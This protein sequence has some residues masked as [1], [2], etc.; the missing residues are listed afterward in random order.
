MTN[1]I[2]TLDVLRQYNELKN[3][4][5][6]TILHG[7]RL[8]NDDVSDEMH[9]IDIRVQYTEGWLD[10]AQEN[11]DKEITT[12]V[13]D[14]AREEEKPEYTPDEIG[15]QP[16][17][18]STSPLPYNLLSGTP[19][20]PTLSEDTIDFGGGKTFTHQSLGNCLKVTDIA[21]WAKAPI[22]PSYSAADVGALPSNTPIPSYNAATGEISFGSTK[23][24]PITEHQSLANCQTKTDSAYTDEQVS[25]MLETI[26][27]LTAIVNEHSAAIQ[28]AATNISTL[29]ANIGT[30]STAIQ[31]VDNKVSA[32]S[33]TNKFDASTISG[34]NKNTG[35]NKFE[36]VAEVTVTDKFKTNAVVA[37]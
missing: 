10:A 34:I 20:I 28:T 35:T 27:T 2:V 14:W 12:L 16:T 30:L 25:Q 5:L 21:D 7:L 29:D 3:K 19:H 32:S 23:V 24:R 37:P 6:N 1:K 36:T 31:T 9:E 8:F 18:T 11:I 13:P 33:D 4:Q 17:I 22:K 15:A 26:K